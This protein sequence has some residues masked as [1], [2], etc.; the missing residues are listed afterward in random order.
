MVSSGFLK[1]VI[2]YKFKYIYSLFFY[3]DVTFCT[4]NIFFILMDCSNLIFIMYRDLTFEYIILH[5]FIF[6][7]NP[8]LQV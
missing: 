7:Q 3:I 5:K 8:G 2:L 6:S 1:I 4:Q